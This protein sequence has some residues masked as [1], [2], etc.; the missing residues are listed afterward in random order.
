MIKHPIRKAF[1]ELQ[2]LLDKYIVKKN[3]GKKIK[4]FWR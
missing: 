3:K 1:N 4:N 2:D